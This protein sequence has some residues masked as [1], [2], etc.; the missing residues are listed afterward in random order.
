M[1]SLPSLL[2]LLLV[3]C[4][5]LTPVVPPAVDSTWHLTAARV[6]GRDLSFPTEPPVTIRFQ[7]DWVSGTYLC[8]TYGA[9]LER[10]GTAISIGEPMLG[11]QGCPP[12]IG[13]IDGDFITALPR[14][15]TAEV[16]SGRL[17]LTGPAVELTFLRG[18]G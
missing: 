16:R 18:D 12:D 14:V 17:V 5:S 15:T 4:G 9:P 13:G 1:R 11:F 10:D 3:G 2:A 7:A 6:E 8:S